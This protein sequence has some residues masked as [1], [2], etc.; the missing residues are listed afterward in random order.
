LSFISDG[1]AFNS[2]NRIA[3]SEHVQQYPRLLAGA[4]L[5]GLALWGIPVVISY[6]TALVAAPKMT[7]PALGMVIVCF[8]LRLQ[9]T[10]GLGKLP[11][12][13]AVYEILFQPA[14][15]HSRD[16]L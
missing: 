5:Y 9:M 1:G 15:R 11:A 7:A 14:E 3:D 4:M 12:S 6:T 8:S 16:K 10:C 13:S 2:G